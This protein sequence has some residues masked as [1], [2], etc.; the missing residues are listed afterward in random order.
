MAD[1]PSRFDPATRSNWREYMLVFVVIAILTGIGLFLPKGYYV[2]V[3]L[4]YLLAITVLSLRVGRW[5]ILTAGILVALAWDYFF[6][7]PYFDIRL[8]IGRDYILIAIY[9]IVA[10]IVGQLTARIRAQAHNERLL[11]QQATAL[12]QFI[13]LLTE[14][15]GLA[16]VSAV[17]TRQM[18]ELLGAQTALAFA[19]EGGR[20]L[21]LRFPDPF[22]ADE[23]E[24]SAAAWVF[25]H[26]Q[27]AGRFTGIFPDCA[28][29]YIP[30][31]RK[32]RAFGVLAVKMSPKESLSS[33]QRDLLEGFARPLALIVEREHLR[34]ASEREKLLAESE[35]LHRALLESVSHEL[36][37]PLAV[38]MATCEKFGLYNVSNYPD[39][40]AEI[41]T[42]GLRLTRLVGNLLDQTRLDSGTLKPRLDW[43]DPRD[44]INAAVKGA[45]SALE[46]HPLK[47]MVSADMPVV[48]ADFALVEHILVNL[49]LN[50]ALHTP[51]GTSV[52]ITAGI[53]SSRARVFFTIADRGPGFPMLLRE[54]LFKKFSRGMDAPAGG[55]GL[56]LS[57]VHGFTVAQG[58]EVVLRDNPG[59][60][61]EIT[62]YLPHI[63]AKNSP[64]E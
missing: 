24:K 19:E 51:S 14:A 32:A 18:D 36:R 48:R 45:G 26:H 22:F 28:G 56:G 23:K 11:K 52:S 44:L 41:H 31:E 40:V 7:Y 6:V 1:Q 54:Q 59:G 63:V 10:L 53:E 47:I 21:D 8:N 9:F 38:I 60:G 34:A 16:E 15:N 46:S 3:G 12:F 13:R 29:Y 35:K 25:G 37:T 62:L 49:L 27:P 55:L 61:A 50:A 39:F 42:A 4:V 33:S 20:G 64:P 57:I 2:Q 58:G 5:P 43:C 17:A 30:L